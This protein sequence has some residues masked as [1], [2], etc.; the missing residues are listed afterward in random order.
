MYVRTYVYGD[1]GTRYSCAVVPDGVGLCGM[2]VCCMYVRMGEVF[3]AMNL[4]VYA[5]TYAHT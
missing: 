2:T 1:L 3:V 4:R 5:N